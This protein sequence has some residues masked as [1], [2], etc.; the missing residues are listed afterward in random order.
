MSPGPPSGRPPGTSAGRCPRAARRI[1]GVREAA[2]GGLAAGLLAA[3]AACPDGRSAAA[4]AARFAPAA[5]RETAAEM[6]CVETFRAVYGVLVG[7]AYRT[8]SDRARFD[9]IY[10]EAS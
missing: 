8:A 6:A 1:D 5:A 7:G 10:G 3:T 4:E 9:S 2:V